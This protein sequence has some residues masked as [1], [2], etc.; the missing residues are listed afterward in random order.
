YHTLYCDRVVPG[1]GGKTCRKIGAHEREKEKQ[2]TETAAR[3]YS[4]IYNRLKAR[5][6]R[7][8]L[9]TDAWNRQ[10]AQAQALKDAFAAGELT[11][12]EYVQKLNAL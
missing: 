6:R 11:R 9:D 8:R 10:V 12:E 1:I 3:E 5:K 7:G 2:R 4:R